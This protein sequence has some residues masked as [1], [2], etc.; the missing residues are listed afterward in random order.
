M[1]KN[2]LFLFLLMFL[3]S[4]GWGQDV[5]Y[6]QD[7][8]TNLDG[9]SHTPSQT[10]S[11]DP[12]DQ[13]F[14]RAVPSN[15]DI[16]EGSVGPYTNVTNSWLFVGSNPNTINSGSPGELLFSSIN[17]SGYTDFEFYADFGAVPNDWDSAD[18]LYVG[19][20]IDGGSWNTL[21]SFD[22]G[23]DGTN[24][25]I[26]LSGNSSGGIN[27]AN[28]TALTYALTT[29]AT[30]NFSGTGSTMNIKIVCDAGANYEAFGVDN[31]IL[32]GTSAGPADPEPTNH[33][34]SFTATENGSSQI[35]FTWSDNDGAQAASGFLIKGSATSYAA[36]TD[37]SDGTSEA[38]GGLVLNV[39]SSVQ[40]ASISSLSELTTYYFKIFP[41]TNS[42][43]DIDYKTDGTI[44]SSNATTEAIPNLFISQ[45][46]DPAD[47]YNGR[48]V[49]IYN[50]SSG[51]N[52][53][54]D[55]WYLAV[56]VNGGSM[57]SYAL[58]GY[59]NSGQTF[60]ITYS[61]TN[62]NM[63]FGFD[64]DA[65]SGFNGSGDDGYYL[66]VGGDHNSG[67]L[68]DAFGVIDQDGSGQD[69]EYTDSKAIRNSDVN[70][71]NAT[72]TSSE[73]TITASSNIA[74][75]SPGTYRDCYTWCGATS[76]S[77]TTTSNWSGGI[78]PSST[79]DVKI[80]N[81][82]D[83]YPEISNEQIECGFLHPASN[84]TITIK[85][86]GGLS[87]GFFSN[88]NSGDL[89]IESDATNNGSFIPASAGG[90]IDVDLYIP[91]HDNVDADGWHLLSMPVTD[92]TF[93]LTGSDFQPGI[94]DDMYW[95]N[96]A[97][98]IWENYK[99][100]TFDFAV[101]QGYLC[102][103]LADGTKVFDGWPNAGNVTVGGL[104][105]TD[106]NP[107]DLDDGWAL[108]GNPFSSDI[109][110]NETG[111][112]WTLN[113]VGG[114][115][116]IFNSSNRNYQAVAADASI[117]S[118]QG[119]FV[120]VDV[121]TTGSVTIP[122]S[123]RDHGNSKW[124][125][126]NKFVQN[127]LKLKVSGGAVPYYDQTQIK[128]RDD[129]TIRYDSRI[130]GHKLFG[131]AETP[132]LY[133]V[134]N[135]EKFSINCL[136]FSNEERTVPLNFK[137]GTNGEF[138]INIEENTVMAEGNI[139]LEDQF[140]DQ[141]INLSTQNSYSFQATTQDNPNRFLLHFNGV[142]GLEEVAAE[143]HIQVYSVDDMIYINSLEDVTADI[144]IYNINGQLIHNEQMNAES[145][146]RISLGTSS[147]VYLV[148]IVTEETST[149]HKVY[150]K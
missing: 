36:I 112:D 105:F 62:F 144:L 18:D 148:N 72:W 38:D 90:P 75:M 135:S 118:M 10:P 55:S 93:T 22:A 79:K 23:G 30:N 20:Q 29:I 149:T 98:Y 109:I 46:A 88:I 87:C 130:D 34:N 28:G 13:Y 2:Y 73:W 58:S 99:E 82:A 97:G 103:Y 95:W 134:S 139:Y 17:I 127:A 136:P 91:G 56:Q 81:G 53:A 31:I 35:D 16:Y 113:N 25:P 52:L 137:A 69:W 141:M 50:A 26:S 126:S 47:E 9:Y 44:P 120:Q 138:T 1:K 49:E 100:T 54:T 61:S 85:P 8:E 15:A 71:P 14:F 21:Y 128:F 70:S 12:G 66:Y 76:T 74:D 116:Q 4:F 110:W 102:S 94:S 123:A 132:R 119:F 131:Y 145:L 77:W 142:T 96:E 140:N 111:G 117:A 59:V 68:V 27:T 114:V 146:K 129:A 101:G 33:V 64:P 41:Y 43:T 104:T 37:P 7:F 125:K 89:I 115:A 143:S 150:M 67:T 106:N 11:S 121:G 51:F 3:A 122:A 133:T 65:Q 80:P 19:Y 40:S 32:K 108:I 48:Y 57:T 24:E 107:G 42:G 124:M 86:D 63:H 78:A 45:V 84:S 39:A 83:F 147:G 92:G 60:V 5:L 6:S